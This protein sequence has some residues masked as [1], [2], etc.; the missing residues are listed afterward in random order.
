MTI[1]SAQI[2]DQS[3]QALRFCAGQ[4]AA[5]ELAGL[6]MSTMLEYKRLINKSISE[7]NKYYERALKQLSKNLGQM[8]AKFGARNTLARRAVRYDDLW[9]K[10]PPSQHDVLVMIDAVY[11]DVE[12]AAKEYDAQLM[13]IN[14]QYFAKIEKLII[15]QDNIEKSI[16][17]LSRLYARD[18]FDEQTNLIKDYLE[19]ALR[20]LSNKEKTDGQ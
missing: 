9:R 8:K 20:K 19:K 7:E 15:Q 13:Q 3:E 12:E 1:T 6:E 4:Q 16:A 2:A 11:T 14:E 5:Q 17:A 10:S 18:E